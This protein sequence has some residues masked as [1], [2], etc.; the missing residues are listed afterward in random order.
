MTKHPTQPV[1]FDRPEILTA[2]QA[3]HEAIWR[4][5]TVVRKIP[6]IKEDDDAGTGYATD[7]I[8][9]EAGEQAVE[10]ALNA[11]ET[12]DN[13]GIKS[14]RGAGKPGTKDAFDRLK[15]GPLLAK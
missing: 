1:E 6:S 4:L 13:F 8:L 7:R 3:L 15:K 5:E 2:K 10:V 9:Q 12:F 11:L 14:G